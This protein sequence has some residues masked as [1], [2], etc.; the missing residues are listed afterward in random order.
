MAPIRNKDGEE[1]AADKVI[2]L[3]IRENRVVIF[4][5]TFCPFCTKIKDFFA[6][7]GIA[8]M[9]LELDTMGNQVG[10]HFRRN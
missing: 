6:G 9:A 7:K 10:V 4:S 5:K 2:D 3:M 1:E 8:Y